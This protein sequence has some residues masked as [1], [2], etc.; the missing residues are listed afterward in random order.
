MTNKL[1]PPKTFNTGETAESLRRDYNPDGSVLRRAQLRLLDMAVYLQRTAK[2]IGVPCRIEGGNVLGTL[3]HDGFIPWDDDIDF[4]VDYKDFHR[5]CDYLKKHPHPQYVLHD[6]D[7][8]PHYYKEWAM[9]RD[10]GST[11]RSRCDADS[12]EYRMHEAQRYKGL[13]IDIFPY[14]ADMIPW[15][16]R[17]AGKLSVN[18]NLRL[19]GRYPLMAEAAYRLLH[20][21]VFP[22][23]RLTGRC[24]GN[25]DLY[26]H[27]YGAWFYEQ[28]PR[29]TMVPH[30]DIMFEGHLFE[31]PADPEE[32]CRI[33]YG[34][35][36][37]LPPRE[38]RDRHKIDIEIR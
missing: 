9:L 35:Y 1:A 6:H 29:R 8:D 27:S 28:F 16:Q 26:M 34:D 3:R 38:Q 32:H 17:L 22:L 4:V 7:T 25:H 12:G 37:Q 23:F 14:E 31:G 24:L 18:V 36:M 13:H 30:K 19:A 20:H 5:L 2:E 15:L 10:L 21:V 33:I 11:T